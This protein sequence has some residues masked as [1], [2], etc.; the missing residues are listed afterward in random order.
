MGKRGGG[1]KTAVYP[2]NK[3]YFGLY[4]IKQEGKMKNKEGRLFWVDERDSTHLK[5]GGTSEK[6]KGEI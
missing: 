4:I 6:E 1:R 2:N 5:S 3:A